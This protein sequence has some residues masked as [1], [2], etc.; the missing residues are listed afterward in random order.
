[1]AGCG[2]FSVNSRAIAKFWPRLL[3]SFSSLSLEWNKT[4]LDNE[5]KEVLNSQS[6]RPP[7][8]R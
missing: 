2:S 5:F 6:I 3:I 8:W 4:A 7:K 1:M